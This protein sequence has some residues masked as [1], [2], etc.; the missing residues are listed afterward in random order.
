MTARVLGCGFSR[1]VWT[2]SNLKGDNA[3]KDLHK[4]AIDFHAFFFN[5]GHNLVIS[6]TL[7]SF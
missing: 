5:T 1:L 3:M 4:L 2:Q 7:R 6:L